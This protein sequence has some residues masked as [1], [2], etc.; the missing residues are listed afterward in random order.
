MLHIKF[1]QDW[2]IVSGFRD[3]KVQKCKIF[4][5]QGQVTPNEWS[6]LVQNQ[7]HRAFMPV[8]VTSNFDDDSIK[9]ECASMEKP[10]SHCKSMGIFLDLKDS[11]LRSQWSD[12]AEIRTCQRFYACPRYLQSVVRSGRNS[13]LSEI[14]CMSSLPASI[15]R[16]RAKITEKRWETS[17]PHCNQVGVF[18]CHG[19]QSA[20][21]HYAVF[22]HPQ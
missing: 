14:L 2:P 21:K 9:Y 17:F 10:F 12:L 15:K 6:D 13:N 16:I 20:S 8:L 11:L 3:I 22:L 1:D 4:V 7:I 19:H 5:T 18:C